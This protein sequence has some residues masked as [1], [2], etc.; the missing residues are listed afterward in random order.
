M[1]QRAHAWVALRAFKLIED[2]KKAPKLVQL[3]SYYLSDVWD[4]AW[5]PDTLIKDMK[6]GH[7]FKMDSD[8]KMLGLEEIAP[9]ERFLTSFDELD[10]R[11]CGNRLC[12]EY[13]AGFDELDKPYRSHPE[14]GGHLPSRVIALSH[15][16]GDM[17]KMSDFP[18]A[19]YAKRGKA[20]EKAEQAFK[21]DLTRQKIKTLSLSPSFSAREIALM[22]FILSHYICDAHMPLHC[23]LR[24]FSI[25]GCKRILPS[26]LHS[27]IEDEWEGYFPEK[28]DINL[29]DYLGK[30]VD[31]IVIESMP[32]D[33]L[34]ELDLGGKYKLGRGMAWGTWRDEYYEMVNV[35]RVSYAMARKWIDQPYMDVKKLL[36]KK[37]VQEF[38][39]IL[40]CIFH[41][42]VESVAR[43]WYK[44]WERYIT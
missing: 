26:K 31:E 35:A 43:I 18:M 24:D 16:I 6:Y 29:H 42:A 14:L 22:F 36:E 21:K 15:T 39:H 20:L 8:P 34:I 10:S 44:A 4:G 12:L 23:D 38:K 41:D 7:V 37:S 5:L 28:E 3:L 19:F 40:N 17:L 27:T 25:R 9:R 32:K 33:S 1:K 2:M 11:L 13:I 30:S